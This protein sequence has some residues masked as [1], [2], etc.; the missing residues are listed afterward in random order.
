MRQQP[1]PTFEDVSIIEI[2]N[3]I[4]QL[5][6]RMRQYSS[7]LDN[8]SALERLVNNPKFANLSKEDQEKGIQIAQAKDEQQTVEQAAYHTPN[9]FGFS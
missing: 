7:S 8:R 5:S 4:E 6:L 3:F 1:D 9:Q 2:L